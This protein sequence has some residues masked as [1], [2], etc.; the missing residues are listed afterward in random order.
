MTRFWA[1]DASDGTTGSKRRKGLGK[2]GLVLVGLG[3]ALV[4]TRARRR[5]R[6]ASVDPPRIEPRAV[7]QVE[8]PPVQPTQVELPSPEPTQVELP[9]LIAVTEQPAEIAP[10][11]SWDVRTKVRI[12]RLTERLRRHRGLLT[13]LA[14]LVVAA[15]L[16]VAVPALI[17]SRN[18]DRWER[19]VEQTTGSTLRS[20]AAV[21]RAVVDEC[22]PRPG[23]HRV[24]ADRRN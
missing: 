7:T 5:S 12:E 16:L 1:H 3:V 8:R 15:A 2:R 4:T 10:G 17:R 13:L 19:C 23:S 22:G 14:V 18:V 24:P 11:P 20:G 9:E 6:Q 21:P